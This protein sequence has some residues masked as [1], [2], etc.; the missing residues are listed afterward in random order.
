MKSKGIKN[1][2]SLFRIMF[3]FYIPLDR[4]NLKLFIATLLSGLISPWNIAIKR[5]M[6]QLSSGVEEGEECLAIPVLSI[7]DVKAC[8]KCHKN[9]TGEGFLPIMPLVKKIQ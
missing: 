2:V 9:N 6:E 7:Q 1:L 4:R 5:R 8:K 3:I